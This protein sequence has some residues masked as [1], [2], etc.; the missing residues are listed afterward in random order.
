MDFSRNARVYDDRH[1]A[2]LDASLAARV[3]AAAGV[4]PGARLLD[5]GA[6]TGRVSVPFAALGHCVVAIDPAAPM[7][8]QLRDKSRTTASQTVHTAIADACALPFADGSFAGVVAARLLYLLPEWRRAI[9]EFARVLRPGGC[10]LHEWG[11][12]EPD[13]PW[14][15]VRDQARELFEAAGVANPFHPGARSEDDVDSHARACAFSVVTTIRAASGAQTTIAQFLDRIERGELSYTWNV[16][17]AVQ[18]TCLPRLR[19][20]AT[21][22]FDPLAPFPAPRTLAWTVYRH[23]PAASPKPPGHEG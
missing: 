10:L 13:E 17:E 7:L 1:G 21:A 5:A 11:N 23:A 19:E 3:I 20:W 4:A 22:R 15:Q 12:G 2:L 8:A 14:V 9:D 18:R 6:G 16:P